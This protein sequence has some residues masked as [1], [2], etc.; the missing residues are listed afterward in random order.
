MINIRKKQ[1][2]IIFILLIIII[3]PINILTS[4][5]ATTN[6]LKQQQQQNQQSIKDVEEE[7]E[8]VKDQM[9]NIQKEVEELNNQISNYEI[10]IVSL[11]N[12]IEDISNN[13]ELMQMEL[14][15]KQKELEEKESMLEKRLVASYKAGDV[16][17]LDFLLG[18]ESL[19]DFLS[20][21]YLIERLAESDTK[22][23]NSIKDSKKTLEE[24]K[25]LLDESKKELENAKE[26]LENKR[27]LLAITKNEKSTKVLQLSE[28]EQELEAKIEE[29][30]AEDA[31][32]VAA[33]KAA[34]A[35]NK[36]QTNTN[37]SSG[38]FAPDKVPGGFAL[39]IPS[40]YALVTAG[41][42]YSNGSTH[43]ATD[44]GAGG[45]YGQPAYA[46]KSGTIMVT[47]NKNDGYG[48]Y[49]TI[50]HH[51]GTYTLYG[52][53]IRGSICV[54]VGQ[55]VSQG[56]QIMQVGSTGNSSG[57]HLHFEIRIGSGTWNERVN[58]L[59]YLPLGSLK[60]ATGVHKY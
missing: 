28:E 32:I 17:Y 26:I 56:Q 37:N 39:P 42:T 43:G 25:K 36:T 29:M 3:I 60:F 24:S 16:S 20:N 19:M 48:T 10:E 27:D 44:F 51:D 9:S 23:I 47:E 14:S 55:E 7:Q 58:P 8:K 53:G 30:K 46:S 41:W 33:I 49:V 34:E 5:A 6:E 50:N 21:Y 57:P 4:Y 54:A 35:A 40:G 59:N 31:K 11:S 12:K 15:K 52:H 45:I 22:L 38:S 13:I 2:K 1:I 18:S